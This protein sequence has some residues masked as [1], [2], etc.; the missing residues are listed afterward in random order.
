MT[1]RREGVS[2]WMV[3]ILVSL[4]AVGGWWFGHVRPDEQAVR[5]QATAA[6]LQAQADQF[7]AEAEDANHAAAA[8]GE[9]VLVLERQIARFQAANHPAPAPVP[10]TAPVDERLAE[11]PPLRASL[12][13]CQALSAVQAQQASAFRE[14][15]D[16]LGRAYAAEKSRADLLQ[17][18]GDVLQVVTVAP[19]Y[20]GGIGSFVDEAEG[21][22]RPMVYLG[23]RLNRSTTLGSG[24][25]PG[26]GFFVI[27]THSWGSLK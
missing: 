15:V 22:V 25:V 13:D 27:V 9:K 26:R 8:S 21:R 7:K 11:I 6:A 12:A 24:I 4:A 1:P 2:P 23:T 18:R 16:A 3:L 5:A 14:Q 19:K 20:E 10:A 17:K